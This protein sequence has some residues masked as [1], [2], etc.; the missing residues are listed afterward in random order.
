MDGPDVVFCRNKKLAGRL[1]SRVLEDQC[2]YYVE[3]VVHEVFQDIPKGILLGFIKKAPYQVKSL[4]L[5]ITPFIYT[6]SK[7]QRFTPSF[8]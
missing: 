8:C 7:F 4:P 6:I 2:G 5:N 1:S 3:L